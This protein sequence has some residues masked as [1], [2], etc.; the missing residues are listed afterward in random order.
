[1]NQPNHKREDHDGAMNALKGAVA[2]AVGVFVMD[3]IDW[4]NWRHEDAEARAQTVSV[5]P[6]G[7]PPAHVVA[8]N[9]EKAAGAELSPTQHEAAGKA[10]HYGLGMAPGAIYGMYRDKIPAPPV[11]R[12]LGYGFALFLLQ[13]EMMNPIAGTAAKPQQYPWQAHAR[14]LVAHLAL[15]LATEFALNALDG[16]GGGKTDSSSKRKGPESG[17]TS[18]SGDAAAAPGVE[19]QRFR[20][21]TAAVDEK[22]RMAVEPA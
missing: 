13:D 5:R 2:G 16:I 14:G 21:P 12:G 22:G 6:H 18:V 4:F 7:E 8:R 15:G 20:G 19:R 1:M 11:A 10:V 9:A 3:R 17:R